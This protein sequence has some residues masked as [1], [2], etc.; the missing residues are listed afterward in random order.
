MSK[1]IDK[2]VPGFV[3]GAIVT[4]AVSNAF[5]VVAIGAL[6]GATI[7]YIA[8]ENTTQDDK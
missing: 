8:Q 5:P 2:A 7:S 6:L 1:N 3:A 4:A